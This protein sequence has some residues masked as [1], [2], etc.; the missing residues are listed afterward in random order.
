MSARERRTAGC[1]R[2]EFLT[3]A[4]AAAA[5]VATTG[6]LEAAGA[7]GG[8]HREVPWLDEVLKPPPGAPVGSLPPLLVDDQGRRIA[9]LEDWHRRRAALEQTWREFLGGLEIDRGRPPVL[10]VLEEDAI[11]DVIRQLVRYDAEPGLATEAYLLAPR[12]RRGRLPGALVFHTTTPESIRQPA[13]LSDVAEKHFGLALARRGF[14]AFCPRNFLWSE[15][16]RMAGQD[17]T[18]RFKARHPRALGMAKMLFDGQVAL[19]ILAA[20]PDVD[21]TRLG[22]IGHSL[23]AKEALY[24]AA[25]D[26]RIKAAVSSEGGIGTT[27]SNWDAEWYLGSDITQPG[28][29]REHHEL[30][31]LIA[32]RPFL[33]VGGDS[34]DGVVSWPFID[35]A[36]P[37]YRLYG[38]P[39]RIGL[40]NHGR[41]HVVPPDVMRRMIEWLETYV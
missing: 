18:R 17:E 1:T 39:T 5:G 26:P 25:F 15:T 4:A 8:R 16:T 38:T 20:H 31:A 14:L 2:R 7:Q 36:L 24:L 41:G 40:L 19:D 33:L 6:S 37:V 13:G 21:P 35:A 34:A 29:A 32:P 22:C 9:T 11:G 23:G 28:S 10:D 3:A 30:L 27:M 12:H